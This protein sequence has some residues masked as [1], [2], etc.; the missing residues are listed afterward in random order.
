MGFCL[1]PTAYCLLF[2]SSPNRKGVQKT[3]SCDSI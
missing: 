2:F 1:L 3:L